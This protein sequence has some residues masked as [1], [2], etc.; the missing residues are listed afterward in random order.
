MLE[1][2]LLLPPAFH[3]LIVVPLGH[4]LQMMPGY[5]DLHILLPLNNTYTLRKL[6][7][8][9]ELLPHYRN[10]LPNPTY[11]SF[12]SNGCTPRFL[13]LASGTSPICSTGGCAGCCIGGRGYACGGTWYCGSTGCGAGAISTFSAAFAYPGCLVTMCV[14]GGNAGAT[15][16]GGVMSRSLRCTAL[17][18]PNDDSKTLSWR[19]F[20]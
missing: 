9:H 10:P 19:T 7:L 4:A 13:C 18:C 17:P 5:I 15:T 8:P 2:L 14:A 1:R 12:P 16:H 3:L 6:H 11:S 20:I